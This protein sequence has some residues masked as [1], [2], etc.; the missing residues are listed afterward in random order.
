MAKFCPDHGGIIAVAPKGGERDIA[1]D[2][3]ALICGYLNDAISAGKGFESE[4]RKFAGEGDDEDVQAAFST[5]AEHT[6]R[7]QELLLE[8]LQQLGGGILTDSDTFAHVFGVVAQSAPSDEIQEERAV[9]RL[10]TAY[11]IEQA[12]G[13]FYETLAA[14]A[15]AAADKTTEALARQIQAEKQQAGK[16][17]FSFIRSR[18]K[19]AYNM[20]TPNELDPA[21]DTKAF[22]NPVV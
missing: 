2:S 21:V 13:A 14:I 10:V 6:K 22:D 4:L 19:I 3:A 7:Q 16:K 18:S 1:H 17:F 12:E 15:A 8:R 11:G 5:R 20:L 9:Y